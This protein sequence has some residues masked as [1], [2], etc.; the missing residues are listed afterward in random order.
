MSTT[1][2]TTIVTTLIAALAGF[3]LLDLVRRLL[4]RT[5]RKGA[6]VPI[7]LLQ[8]QLSE[9]DKKFIDNLLT[10]LK[11]SEGNDKIGMFV[12]LT[13]GLEIAATLLIEPRDD[14]KSLAKRFLPMQSVF[15]EL[16]RRETIDRAVLEAF[17]VFWVIRNKIIHGGQVTPRELDSGLV[18]GATLL[19]VLL[20][21]GPKPA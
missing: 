4:Y 12:K 18:L 7:G 10:K 20:S 17:R 5:R 14:P 16:Y 1:D 6:D 11:D 15:D 8:P 13:G 21:R 2:I 3:S 9:E 19:A